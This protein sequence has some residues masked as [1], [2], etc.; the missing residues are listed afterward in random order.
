M[1]D[2]AQRRPLLNA[3]ARALAIVIAV[4]LIGFPVVLLL[5][6][7]DILPPEDVNAAVGYSSGLDGL[8]EVASSDLTSGKIWFG[9]ASALLAA[10]ALTLLLLLLLLHPRSQDA[11]VEAHPGR[12]VVLR[13]RALRHLAEGAAR[14]AGARDATVDVSRR[15][16]G[17]EL[18][19]DMRLTEF[20]RVYEA[21][22]RVS[23]RV[24]HELTDAGVKVKRVQTTVRTPAPSEVERERVQ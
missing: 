7:Y 2:L 18:S 17:Y 21:A 22:Q 3:L 13:A 9:V 15:R 8:Q 19:C 6:A 14:S 24:K 5:I 16:H 10:A 4:L 1:N 11:T 23:D 20:E 12:E